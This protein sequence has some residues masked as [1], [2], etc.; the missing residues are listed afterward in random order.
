[1]TKV[2]SLAF[3]S[4]LFCFVQ[5]VFFVCVCL[6]VPVRMDPEKFQLLLSQAKEL[7]LTGSDIQVFIDKFQERE[8]ERERDQRARDE[9][10]KLK[11]LDLAA[12]KEKEAADLPAKE[13]KRCG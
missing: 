7:G 3:V 4:F 9:K 12:K 8:D 2:G 11:Q 10:V 13:K 6:S 5:S 1:M